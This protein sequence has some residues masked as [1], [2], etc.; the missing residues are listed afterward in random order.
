MIANPS[1]KASGC[2]C[3]GG[4]GTSAAGSC[5]CGGSCASCQGQGIVRPRFF[6]G[7][8]LTEDDLQLMTDYVGY[9]DRLHNRH[10]FGA[11]VVCGLDVTCHPCGGGQVIV[12]PGYALDC[13]GNDLTLACEQPLD[14][15]AMVRDLR[16]D[17]LGGYDCGDPCPEAV[18]VATASANGGDGQNVDNARNGAFSEQVQRPAASETVL[19]YCL[20]VRYDEQRSDPVMPYS[21][22]DDCGSVGCEASRVREGVKFELRCRPQMDAASPLIERL[23]ACVGDLN[24]FRRVLEAFNN[25]D[26]RTVIAQAALGTD[27]VRPFTFADGITLLRVSQDLDN[28]LG[29]F[30]F[31]SDT[32]PPGLIM[33]VREAKPLVQ[34]FRALSPQ[35]QER[36]IVGDQRGALI[37][38]RVDS[39]I[40]DAVERVAANSAAH[41][42]EVRDWL[43]ERVSNSPYLTDCT[44]RNKILAMGQPTRN[45][46]NQT[47]AKV[48]V[49]GNEPLIEVFVNYL[50]DCVSRAVNPACTSGEDSAVLLACLDIQDCNVVKIC[51]LER[52]FVLSPAAVRYWLPPLQLVGNMVERLLCDP[53]ENLLRRPGASGLD[54]D[55]LNIGQLLGDE[56]KRILADSLCLLN[57][58]KLGFLSEGVDKVLR[59]A[60]DRPREAVA[61]EF[62]SQFEKGSE[63]TKVD[64][65]AEAEVSAEA[66][67]E[68]QI[69]VA[70]PIEKASAVAPKR[71][72]TTRKSKKEKE[73]EAVAA[74]EAAKP[75]EP[76]PAAGETNGK[77]N[78]GKTNGGKTNGSVTNGAKTTGPKG[79]EK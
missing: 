65:S 60:T 25:L 15:N 39:Q 61:Q 36:L 32:I 31:G 73:A 56:A 12:H 21:T 14:I 70:S 19:R 38:D 8:L 5:G 18:V 52:T 23:C 10:L 44:L 17:Q 29:A 42:N 57:K 76:P 78:G 9:K 63:A 62:G 11:G 74:A 72:R 2:G 67:E 30:Q 7:Q 55:N 6:A 22:G 53:L 26:T 20:Y 24:R 16:R 71:G 49:G 41:F 35:A 79:D 27:K 13:C 4:G 46:G 59:K 28:E 64:E 75:A 50:R 43:V 48:I 3:G 1:Y 68:P 54:L 47:Q 69:V 77:T 34:S 33:S 66:T 37:A 51:N 58:D 40:S 45:Q